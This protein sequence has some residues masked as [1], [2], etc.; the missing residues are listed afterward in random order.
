MID[1]SIK[2]IDN[3]WIGL[4]YSG[5]EIIATSLDSE[6]K[7]TLSKVLTSLPP[8]VNY[9]IAEGVSEFAEKTIQALGKIH[10]GIQEFTNFKLAA[11][12]IS[13]PKATVLRAAASIPTGY[14][15]S[16]GSIAKVAD[17]DPRV[18]GQI[19][20]SNP[21]YPIVPCHRVVG[22]DFSLVGY[23][24]SKSQQ[25]LRAKLKRLSRECRRFT[26]VKKISING[27]TLTM[28][29]TEN[30]IEKAKKGKLSFSPKKQRT[31]IQYR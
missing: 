4:A 15:S 16:Y 24:G 10:D 3:V 8:N 6:R 21:L 12:F 26:S 23:G 7:K 30:V 22:T 28:H 18:V 25:A 29:P 17:T 19:M 27:K 11:E 9:Q 1:I 14:V 31:L 13:E 5:K 20:A 2:K